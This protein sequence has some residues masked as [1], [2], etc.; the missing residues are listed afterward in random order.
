MCVWGGLVCG[1][2]HGYANIPLFFMLAA[3]AKFANIRIGIIR[4]IT[5]MTFYYIGDLARDRFGNEIVKQRSGGRCEVV[6]VGQERCGHQATEV[7][8]L[9]GGWRIRG[10]G[11]SALAEHK[12]HV[13]EQ[14]HARITGQVGCGKLVLVNRGTFGRLP[15]WD[16]LYEERTVSMTRLA[17]ICVALI[18]VCGPSLKAQTPT[19]VTASSGISFTPSSDHAAT[20][21][22]GSPKLSHYE[23][24][25][26]PGIGCQT[27]SPVNIGKPMPVSGAILVQ[28]IAGMGTLTQNCLYMGVIVAVGPGGEGVSILSDPFVRSVPQAPAAPGKPGVLP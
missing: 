19:P 16:D 27:M 18:M 4:L 1:D 23:W 28:P 20:N 9:I 25:Y 11:L 24:R 8:H 21:A 2:D 3:C 26:V 10:R 22:D 17:L 7:H 6:V 14:H 5:P 13:C 15:R 12:Q